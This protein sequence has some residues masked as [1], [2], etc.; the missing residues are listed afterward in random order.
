MNLSCVLLDF[1]IRRQDCPKW[2]FIN[3]VLVKR[4]ACRLLGCR[5]VKT[6]SQIVKDWVSV[7]RTT[8][9]PDLGPPSFQTNGY[10]ELFPRGVNRPPSN[11]EIKT[12]L[13]YSIPPLLHRPTSSR[14]GAYLSTRRTFRF[15]TYRSSVYKWFST[16]SRAG[17]VCLGKHRCDI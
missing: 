3:H 13:R 8:S 7:P 11:A 16:D 5:L 17:A 4:Y 14:C 6:N 2:C 12:T 15:K 1:N 9:R 10:R